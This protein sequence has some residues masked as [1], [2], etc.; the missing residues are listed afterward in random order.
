[1]FLQRHI[2][3]TRK[4]YIRSHHWLVSVQKAR[5]QVTSQMINTP[6]L[7]NEMNVLSLPAVVVRYELAH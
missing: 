1:M 6:R 2:K 3:L 5:L 7:S 4:G